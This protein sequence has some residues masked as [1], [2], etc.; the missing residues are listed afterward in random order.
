MCVCWAQSIWYLALDPNLI[1]ARSPSWRHQHLLLMRDDAS[2][3]LTMTHQGFLGLIP[4]DHGCQRG[5]AQE[6]LRIDQIPFGN[7]CPQAS[8]SAPIELRIPRITVVDRN[9]T[10]GRCF[11]LLV[12]VFVIAAGLCWFFSLRIVYTARLV[13]QDLQDTMVCTSGRRRCKG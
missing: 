8:V 4:T 3:Q 13:M 2:D 6:F 7:Y 12:A 5:C 11:M 1:A 10:F 9:L